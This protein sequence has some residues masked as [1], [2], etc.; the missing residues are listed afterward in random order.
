MGCVGALICKQGAGCWCGVLHVY[1]ISLADTY[2][3]FAEAI[4]GASWKVSIGACMQM[5][6]DLVL[7]R[8]QLVL[9][10]EVASQPVIQGRNYVLGV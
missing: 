3:S 2:L 8:T 7:A 1:P 6:I 10:F 9:L 5:P 4:A